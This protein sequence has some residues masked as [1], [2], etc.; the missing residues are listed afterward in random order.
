MDEGEGNG[1]GAAPRQLIVTV[2][3][4]YSREH[5]GWLSVASLVG[6]L[7]ELGVDEPAVRSSISRLKR[8]GMLH[9]SKENGAAGYALS[10][11]ALEILRE[12]DERIF[13]TERATVADGWVLAVFSVPESQRQRRHVLRTQLTKLGFGMVAPGMWIAPAQ[14]RETATGVLRRFE[15]D[16]YA[17]VFEAK[18][19]AFGSLEQKVAEWWDLTELH[20]LYTEFLETHAPVLAR[21]RRKRTIG[22]R[23]AFADY[24]R[25]LTDWRRLPYSDP[26]LPVELLPADWA[27]VQA[28]DVFFALNELLVEPAH[29]YVASRT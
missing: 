5:G 26:G 17:D 24:V 7:A 28:A 18:H 9:A 19:L 29:E 27:G 21:W 23:E 6:L 2:Y 8:R 4:L 14:L 3:G 25:A 12:G 16:A 1:R 22:Q 11:A 10:D 13:R 20:R 15:L